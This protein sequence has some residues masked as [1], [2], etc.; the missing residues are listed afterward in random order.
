MQTPFRTETYKFTS[1]TASMM[2]KTSRMTII[3]TTKSTK[4][5]KTATTKS[6]AF[7]YGTKTTSL[8]TTRETASKVIAQG[9]ANSFRKE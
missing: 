5:M 7:I 8:S 4:T 9:E 2:T 6:S 1:T 3:T